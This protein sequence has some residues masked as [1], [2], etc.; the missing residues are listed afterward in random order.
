M[1]VKFVVSFYVTYDKISSIVGFDGIDD[2]FLDGFSV[3]LWKV[4]NSQEIQFFG[5]R[6]FLDRNV[7]CRGDLGFLVVGLG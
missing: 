2:A 1:S 5:F 4:F 3:L 6:M 7:F